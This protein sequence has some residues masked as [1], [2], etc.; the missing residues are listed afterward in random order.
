MKLLNLLAFALACGAGA[1]FAA[2]A[3]PVPPIQTV[4]IMMFENKDWSDIVGN[5][6]CPYINSLLPRASYCEQYYTPPGNHP[7]EPNYLWLE[8]GTN[9]GISDDNPPAINSQNTTNHLVTL[10][11]NAGISWKTY[12]EGISGTC[13]PL[14]IIGTNYDPKH[15]PFV[16]FDDDTGTNDPNYAYGIAHVRPFSELAGDLASNTVARYNLITPDLCDD[17]HDCPLSQSD[18]WLSQQLPLILASP[19]YTN[20][21]A[22]FICWDEGLNESDGPIGM[23]VLSPLAR[24]GGYHNNIHYDHGSTLR[25]FQEIFHVGPFLN[26]AANATD[27]SDL[28]G[29]PQTISGLTS[30]F[31][32][33]QLTVGGVIP[34]HAYVIE[35]STDLLKWTPMTTNLSLSSSFQYM[36]GGAFAV[37]QRF[38]RIQ[39]ILPSQP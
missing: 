39:P 8:A 1:I 29:V 17:G 5:T 20:N 19:A 30:A 35:C 6:N 27:L 10:L 36:D 14:S 7:S 23:I 33:F 9:F 38:Y 26:A 4:F 12:Q 24:G 11:N 31:G 16:F 25:T 3:S 15:D 13:L 34:N 28:F 37:P 2:P 18:W 21:G 22:V 32:G